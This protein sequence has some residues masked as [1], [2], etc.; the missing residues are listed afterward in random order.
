MVISREGKEHQTGCGDVIADGML[1]EF[2]LDRVL[3]T[4]WRSCVRSRRPGQSQT[5]SNGTKS[6][7]HRKPL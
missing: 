1:T 5:W 4:G 2:P 6:A 3:T 7:G